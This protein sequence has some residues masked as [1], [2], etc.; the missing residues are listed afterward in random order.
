MSLKQMIRLLLKNFWLIILVPL[1]VAVGVYFLAKN[2]PMR[3]ESSA[4]VFTNP[5]SDR[6][7][8]DGGAIRMDFYTSNNLFDNLT[9]L[10]RS[11]ETVTQ[12]SLR[13]LALH[14]IQK[15]PDE[16]VLSMENFEEL[17]KHIDDDLRSK[18]VVPNDLNKTHLR[19]SEHLQANPS[20]PVEYLLRE[21]P[22]YGVS[23]IIKELFVAR[24]A[25]S[26]MM[27]V[28]YRTDDAANC[29][30][31]L[32]FITEA[33][34]ERYSGIKEAE[35]INSILYFEDQLRIAQ[36]KLRNAEAELKDFMTEHRILNYYEQG[37]YLDIAK[38]EHEQDE[39]RSR[40]ILSG[41]MANLAKIEGLFDGFDQRQSIIN[42]ISETQKEIVS[43]QL[44]LE[45]AQ[46]S[47]N[48]QDLRQQL[49]GEINQLQKKIEE[50]ST[51]L[52]NNS[53]S[54]EGLQRREALD[55]WLKLKLTYEEQVQALDVMQERKQYLQD[56]IDEFAP[57]GAELKRLER[58]V[59]VSESQYLS[60]LHGLNMAYLK[61]YDLE[62]TSPQK[63]IDEPFFP[64][65]PLPS[66][67]L[68]L[69]VGG[70]FGSGFFT[71]SLV[72]LFFFLDPTVKSA[73]HA[74]KLT[75]LKVAG[76]WANEKLLPR[77]VMKETMRNQLITQFRNH[78]NRFL[79]HSSKPHLIVFYSLS[80]GSGKTF[81]INHYI[82]K[83]RSLNQTVTYYSPDTTPATTR[84][85]E[86]QPY[87][88]SVDLL[89]GQ[90]QRWKSR[91]DNCG[92]DYFF[93]ELPNLSEFDAN[94][95]LMNLSETCILVLSAAQS[96]PEGKQTALAVIRE[97]ITSPHLVW[98]NRMTT[99][100]LEDLHGEIPKKRT[101]IRRWAK[102]LIS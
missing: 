29:Y 24:K 56:K 94:Y 13:L 88:P 43:K 102:S 89:A 92:S 37:K 69:V 96:F 11:R 28:T 59:S 100:E 26:D 97:A 40:R 50:K 98:L 68:F 79:D 20:S 9:L 38:L 19:I 80:D 65:K 31:T 58:E 87:D 7:V 18:L 1:V 85:N 57:L 32:K 71:A 99:D 25:S 70:M 95:E 4:I 49:T 83:I 74:E 47:R 55:E 101:K 90:T 48:G 78:L 84:T 6:G 93:L 39:E 33:F 75:G 14:L 77:S 34:M 36:M 42:E 2:L 81:L 64:K 62:M 8:N 5:T 21:H 3:F 22:H 73:K 72:V 23:N 76:G 82:E 66:K 86:Q 67:K 16:E 51:L 52:F 54:L 10:L 91:V 53:I 41:T 12:A 17:K 44:E 35:N 30:Y 60:I 46:L 27:E 63:L 61:K 15:Q 45:G